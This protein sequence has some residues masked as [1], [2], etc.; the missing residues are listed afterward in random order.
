MEDAR[1]E[2][3][4]ADDAQLKAK[5][6]LAEATEAK[7]YGWPGAVR[8]M[9]AALESQMEACKEVEEALE[10]ES[11]VYGIRLV[12]AETRMSKAGREFVRATGQVEQKRSLAA[13]C[14]LY[15]LAQ[16]NNPHVV[17]GKGF[18]KALRG[19]EAADEKMGFF[20]MHLKEKGRFVKLKGKSKEE[21]AAEEEEKSKAAREREEAA[22]NEKNKERLEGLAQVIFLFLSMLLLLLLTLSCC[23][24]CWSCPR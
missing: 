3:A 2:R 13:Q 9:E 1:R 19:Y 7:L 14:H 18:R 16:E 17:Y 5:K 20:L 23:C 24:C 11:K 12:Q 10:A 8:R 15:M 6:Q 22:E 4:E 21:L